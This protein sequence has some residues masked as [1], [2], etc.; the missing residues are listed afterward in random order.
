VVFGVLWKDEG[1]R[2][3]GMEQNDCTYKHI[4]YL[5]N[6]ITKSRSGTVKSR[7]AIYLQGGGLDYR[8]GSGYGMP[9]TYMLY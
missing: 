5:Q 9:G 7:R 1:G 3:E 8:G 2:R 6:K 4:L